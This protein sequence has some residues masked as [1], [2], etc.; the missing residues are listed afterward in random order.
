M[1][2]WISFSSLMI[3]EPWSRVLSKIFAFAECEQSAKQLAKPEGLALQ[4]IEPYF[5]PAGALE[6]VE[7]GD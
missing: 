3:Q 7:V 4:L 1:N 2:S 5:G 6:L